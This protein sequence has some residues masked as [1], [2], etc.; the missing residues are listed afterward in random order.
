LFSFRTAIVETNAVKGRSSY[1]QFIRRS[2][3]PELPVVLLEDLGALLGLVF[4]MVAV[5]VSVITGDGRW[6][7]YGSLVIGIL[8]GIIAIVLAVEMKSL[9]IGESASSD[10]REAIAA[11][12]MSEP[13]VLKLIHMR[14]QHL[15]PDE[16]LVGAKVEFLHDLTLPEVAE[17]VNRLEQ[18]VRATVPSARIMYIEPDVAR[19]HRVP[20]L[21]PEHGG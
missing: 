9:L 19:E 1:R 13:G 14:T 16:L 4:A 20:P 17:A 6:D 10:Q 15:G 5:I 2:K 8:L 3:T 18:V 21:V 11:T 12:I 7:G